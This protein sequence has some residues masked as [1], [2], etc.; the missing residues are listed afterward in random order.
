MHLVAAAGV[1]VVIGLIAYVVAGVVFALLHV[2][3]LLLVA[4]LAG[5]AGY[6]VGLFRGSRRRR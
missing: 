1:I 2:L 3:E 5:W 4:G 6:R